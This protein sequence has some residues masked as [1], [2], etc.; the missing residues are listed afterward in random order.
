[1]T[2]R[3]KAWFLDN[4][5]YIIGGLILA[6]VIAMFFFPEP[7]TNFIAYVG[8][9]WVFAIVIGIVFMVREKMQCEP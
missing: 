1:V 8:M 2:I 9:V 7:Q 4:S 5:R 3:M 6:C